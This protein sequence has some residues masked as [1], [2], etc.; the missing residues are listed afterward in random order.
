MI[1]KTSVDQ[2]YAGKQT[3]MAGFGCTIDDA[4]QASCSVF[5]ALRFAAI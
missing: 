2:A 3:F 4:V 5:R 1:F